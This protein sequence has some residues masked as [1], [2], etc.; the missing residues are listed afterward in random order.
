MATCVPSEEP[1]TTPTGTAHHP[2]VVIGRTVGLVVFLAVAFVGARNLLLEPRTSPFDVVLWTG[3]LLMGTY[4]C[5]LAVASLAN[6][7]PAGR[8]GPLAPRVALPLN[9]LLVVIMLWAAIVALQFDRWLAAG[10]SAL[11]AVSQAYA[12]WTAARRPGA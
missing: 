8:N 1:V 12:A 10:C 2:V 6:R 3:L 11:V 4:F 9:V 5:L 7:L